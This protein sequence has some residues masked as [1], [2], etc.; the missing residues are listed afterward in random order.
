MSL[1]DGPFR[2]LRVPL[3]WTAAAA[4]VV[5]IIVGVAMLFGDR[6]ETFQGQAIGATRN[7]LDTVSKP[8]T[9]VVSAPVR[10]TGDVV[11]LFH[12]YAF[13]VAEN[14]RL[15][16]QVVE[17]ER[18]RDEAIFLHNDNER[19]RALMGLKTDPPIPMVAAEV[20][21]DSRGP[22]ADTRLADAGVERGV[23]IGNPVMSDRGLVGHIIGVADGVSR[24]LLA[25]DVSSRIPVMDERT[26]A[27]AILTGDGGRAPRLDYLRGTDP[28]KIGDRILTSGD[29]GLFPRGL[30]VGVA[31]QGFDGG[32]R[33]RLDS[34]DS[35][36]DYVRILLFKDFSQLASQQ[37]LVDQTVPPL[38]PADAAEVQAEAAAASK[39]SARPAPTAKAASAAAGSVTVKTAAPVKP[40]LASP[41]KTAKPKSA[42]HRAA[43]PKPAEPVAEPPSPA[44]APS[45]QGNVAF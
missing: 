16:A 14:P 27:R 45:S 18:Q 43:E 25:T 31:V 22:F 35:P 7:A 32:W 21:A 37:A 38:P 24:V 40:I 9:T 13:A 8:V 34:D 20:I 12:Q 23:T 3:T 36:I 39:S 42:E 17:L 11:N 44:A 15:K 30:P 5:A 6:R 41:A 26:N 29:G 33:V 4:V 19:L 28:L 10:W 2:D 1:R